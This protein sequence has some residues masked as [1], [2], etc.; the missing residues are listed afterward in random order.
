MSHSFPSV[1]DAI[2]AGYTRASKRGLGVHRGY[3]I[4]IADESGPNLFGYRFAVWALPD[5]EH[6]R[7]GYTNLGPF[8]YTVEVWTQDRNQLGRPGS[9]RPMFPPD[10]LAR[11]IDEAH[12]SIDRV[13]RQAK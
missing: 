8:G 4:I 7:Q 10:E 12:T 11:A 9:F 3:D 2:D 1:T 13:F 5:L 6:L